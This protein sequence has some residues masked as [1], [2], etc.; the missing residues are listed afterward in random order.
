MMMLHTHTHVKKIVFY[1]CVCVAQLNIVRLRLRKESKH[2]WQRGKSKII[3]HMRCHNA[4]VEE[5]ICT[6]Y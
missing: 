1:V 3:P 4:P 6:Q 2:L 5:L